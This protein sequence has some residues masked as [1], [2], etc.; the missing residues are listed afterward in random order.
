M[1]G[2]SIKDITPVRV[3]FG[4]MP[5]MLARG[6]VDAYVGAEPGPGLSITSGR[7]SSSNIPTA[8]RWAA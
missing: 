7:A 1:E 4:E 5:A 2:M 6:D 3:P 8:P